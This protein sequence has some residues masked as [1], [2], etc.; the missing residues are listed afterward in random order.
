VKRETTANL[1]PTFGFSNKEGLGKS[2]IMKEGL[3][4]ISIKRQIAALQRSGPHQS[5]FRP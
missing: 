5:F 1:N 4:V 2:I 3:T